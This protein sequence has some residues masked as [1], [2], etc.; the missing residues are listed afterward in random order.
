MLAV[1]TG[2]DDVRRHLVGHHDVMI[3]CYNS[4]NRITPSGSADD[5]SEVAKSLAADQVF[6]RALATGGNAYHSHHINSLGEEYEEDLNNMLLSLPP[7]ERKRL[8]SSNFF[9]SK[10]GG[11]HATEKIDSTYG[12]SN[13]ESPVLFHQALVSLV[14]TC[15]VDVIL[16]I[17]PDTALKSPIRQISNSMPDVKLPEYIASQARERDGA[18]TLLQM[19]GLLFAKGRKV[20]ME[21]VNAIEVLDTLT[22]EI[23]K[24]DT[25]TTIVDL[26]KYQWQYQETLFVE[27]RWTRE[28]R[29]RSHPRHDILGS[30][31]PGGNKNEPCWRNV[32]RLKDLPW[33]ADHKVCN[34]S[35][36][37]RNKLSG[38]LGGN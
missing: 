25:G 13:L 36:S 22:N 12:R 16:E 20:A 17:G 29:L 5:I 26:P 32:L 8:P 35:Q 19:V 28:R 1:G 37:E 23:C 15:S 33:L 38:T 9:S 21:R 11:Y 27:N 24:V 6:V 30:R 34:N 18:E 31:N 4:P 3:A 10:I 2:A 14:E 7:S